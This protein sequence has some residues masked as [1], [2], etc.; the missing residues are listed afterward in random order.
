LLNRP[1]VLGPAFVLIWSSG[2]IV[3]AIASRAAAPLAV[4]FWRLLVAGVILAVLA[5]VRGVRWPRE[6]RVLGGIAL[7]GALLFSVQFGGVYLGLAG[8]MPAGT[9]A[10]LVSA[11]PLV[12]ALAQAVLGFERLAARQ[13]LGAGLGMT[14][15]VVALLG[16]LSSPGAVGPVLWTLLGLAGFAAANV[17]MPHLVPRDVDVRA[18]TSIECLAAGVVMAPWALLH[19]G[20]AVPLTG[21]AV[22][23]AV[24]LT[25]VNGVGGALLILA[26]VQAR[27]ATRTSSLLFVVPAT[28]ALASWPV[29]GE[30]I[31]VPT[32]AGLAIAGLGILLV[33]HRPARGPAEARRSTPGPVASTMA[34]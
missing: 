12:V 14:G 24:W 20:L 33:Q 13:W 8:G 11:C 26:L 19:G 17:L 21:P 23:S 30:P 27:G 3:G 7:V 10:L 31:R 22:G 9:S 2:Y 34:E 16:H 32:L 28:T 4:T 6:P 25:L 5:L 1:P 18:V 29:L 15:V